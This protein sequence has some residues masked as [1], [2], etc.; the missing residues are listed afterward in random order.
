[1][2]V[3]MAFKATYGFFPLTT[4][5][6]A[7]GYSTLPIMNSLTAFLTRSSGNGKRTGKRSSTSFDFFGSWQE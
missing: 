6:Y 5:H 7:V 2:V 1:M 3:P 4:L